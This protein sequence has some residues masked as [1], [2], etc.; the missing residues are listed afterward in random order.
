MSERNLVETNWSIRVKLIIDTFNVIVSTISS[1]NETPHKAVL[2]RQNL[3][4]DDTNGLNGACNAH[5][6]TSKCIGCLNYEF[7]HAYRM[8][9]V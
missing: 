8:K 6:D 9:F 5:I 2:C 4:A 3:T 7:L 1:T